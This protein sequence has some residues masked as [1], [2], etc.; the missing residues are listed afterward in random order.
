MNFC[1]VSDSGTVA[2]VHY[3]VTSSNHNTEENADEFNL[4][5]FDVAWD[6]TYPS[7]A[8]GTCQTTNGCEV[9]GQDCI[10]EVSIADNAVFVSL[11]SA[12][13][14]LNTLKVGAVDV[15]ASSEYSLLGQASGVEAYQKN[16]GG[17]D[18][19]AVFKVQ[20]S[21]YKNLRSEVLIGGGTY[22][23]RNPVQFLNPALREPRDAAHETDAVLKHYFEHPNTA[24][25]LA[26]RMIQRFGTSNPSPAYIQAVAEAFRDGTYSSNG[27]VF[28]QGDYGSME[29]MVA[30]IVLHE[31]SRE[32]IL[33]ADPTS[34][35]LREPLLKFIGFMRSL[36]I[37]LTS[38]FPELRLPNLRD[39]LGQ[40]A[41]DIPSVFSFFLP[42]YAAPGHVEAA[43]ITSPE[44]QVMNGPALTAHVNGHFSLIETGLNNCYN[45]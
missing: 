7:V 42:E 4:N 3:P 22:S 5:F 29:A 23:F 8:A 20:N 2:V 31:E 16:G 36:K 10:C 39:R 19:E 24:P 17:Y 44:A 12:N 18:A 27:V 45:G 38:E 6:T 26:S 43:T 1:I 37:T 13:D 9:F 41:H 33:D 30:A 35:S 34:G 11:P 28:G 14:V 25:F 40:N 21:F 32:V 15:T